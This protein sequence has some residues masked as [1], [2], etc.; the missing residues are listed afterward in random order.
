MD[1][2]L[3]CFGNIVSHSPDYTSDSGLYVTDMEAVASIA[4]ISESNNNIEWRENIKNKSDNAI[5]VAIL[6]LNTDLT[7]LMLRYAKPKMGYL[8]VVGSTRFTS[9]VNQSGTSGVRMICN[10]LRDVEMILT[11]VTLTFKET[12]TIDLNLASN[13]GDVVENFPGLETVAGKPKYNALETPLS[14]EMFDPNL[15]RYVEYY[16]YHD[17]SLTAADNKIECASCNKFYFNADNP[18][19]THYGYRQYLN[20]GGFNS[21]ID[22]LDY[23]GQNQGN[24]IMLH[25]D[26]RCDSTKAICA[27]NENLKRSPMFM[28]YA[29]AIQY[30]AASNLVW[31][32]IRTPELNRVVMGD[33]ESLRDAASFY[34]RK[35]NDMVKYIS[36]NMPIES[37]CFCEQGFTKSTISH[38]N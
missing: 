24:G 25:L 30:K 6:R 13:R 11:G 27:D 18:R 22:D 9:Y 2:I 1:S 20:I 4:G 10:S 28:S 23:R 8:G 33:I 32:M 37:D 26:I 17:N 12:G 14:L 3:N 21:P 19:F 15:D 31:E 38:G 5:R 35:Y 16:L 34:D 36:K 7:T 29:T